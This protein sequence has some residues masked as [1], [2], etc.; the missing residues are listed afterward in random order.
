MHRYLRET[1]TGQALSKN[2]LYFSPAA[3]RMAYE[4]ITR[5]GGTPCDRP[6]KTGTRVVMRSDNAPDVLED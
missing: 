4:L 6:P 3:V 2:L 5:E 1:A